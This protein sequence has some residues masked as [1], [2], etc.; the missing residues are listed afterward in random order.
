MGSAESVK[1]IDVAVAVLQRDNGDVLWCSRPEGKPYAGYWEFPGGKVEPNESVWQALVREIDEE[2]GITVQAGGPWMLVEHDY[3]HAKVRLHLMRVWK[4][5]G[6]P[7]AREQ[8]RFQWA[9][10]LLGAANI[11]PILPATEPLLRK[12]ALPRVMLLTQIELYCLEEFVQRLHSTLSSAKTANAAMPLVQFREKNLSP[13]AQIEAVAAVW[14]AL[15]CYGAPMVVNSACKI[16]CEWAANQATT[17][18]ERLD[19]E[20]ASYNT[21][22]DK[23]YLQ[24]PGVHWTEHDL[25]T[26]AQQTIDVQR[27]NTASVHG[28]AGLNKAHELGID[29]AVLGTVLPSLSHPGGPTL[30]WSGFMSIASQARLPV[31]GI[32]GLTTGDLQVAAEHAAHGVAVMRTAWNAATYYTS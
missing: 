6:E 16:A 25:T 19:S 17:S 15:Q 32:G 4:W 30:G 14:D 10:S 28:A 8:Q 22:L 12:L 1:R 31:Y 2:L 9:P 5:H 20:S 27:M 11:Q 23:Q 26:I 24:R 3:P 18:L 7:V 13:Q 29:A 21:S